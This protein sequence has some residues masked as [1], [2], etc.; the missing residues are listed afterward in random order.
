MHISILVR[1]LADGDWTP[2]FLTSI[3]SIFFYLR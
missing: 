1:N 2:A 3:W